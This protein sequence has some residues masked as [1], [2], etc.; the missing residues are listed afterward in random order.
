MHFFVRVKK[1][2]NVKPNSD[3]GNE[4]KNDKMCL[5]PA[6]YDVLWVL[7]LGPVCKWI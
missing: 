5:F 6:Q 3:V 4:G 2:N 7:L 1:A